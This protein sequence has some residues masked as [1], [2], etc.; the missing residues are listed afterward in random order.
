MS[1]RWQRCREIVLK[2]ETKDKQYFV[3]CFIDAIIVV[4]HLHSGAH[5]VM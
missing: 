1:D 3:A 2:K 4:I 5:E